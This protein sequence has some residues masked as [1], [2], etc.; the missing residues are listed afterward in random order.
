[1]ILSQLRIEDHF[2]ALAAVKNSLVQ[3]ETATFLAAAEDRFSTDLQL[4]RLSWA[5]AVQYH[6]FLD[7]SQKDARRKAIALHQQAIEM[8]PSSQGD[9]LALAQLNLW[10]HDFAEAARG[11]A[12]ALDSAEWD[13]A[14]AIQLSLLLLHTGKE[15]Q[16]EELMQRISPS[17]VQF[18]PD[19]YYC[20]A[21][22]AE[23]QGKKGDARRN[24]EKAINIR[25]YNP[26][27]HRSYA[28][29]LEAQGESPEKVA[30]LQQW[31][32]RID[33]RTK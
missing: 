12:G 31:A 33:A 28:A 2:S 25:K 21:L 1:M 7:K 14:V 10:N 9:W 20:L 22:C 32:D 3:P 11:Y 26:A 6:D 15:Q 13:D 8:N 29:F 5:I 16:A 30:L 24:Y 23:K 19:Y 18:K 17:A 27:Y 4:G